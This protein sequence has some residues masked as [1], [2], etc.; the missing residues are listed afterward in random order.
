[1]TKNAAAEHAAFGTTFKRTLGIAL[2]VAWLVSNAGAQ[3]ASF[4]TDGGTPL[5]MSPGAPAGSYA[6]SG[7][8]SVNLYNGLST[9]AC[10]CCTSGA[11]VTPSL[12]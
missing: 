1:M 5:G 4:A 6:L 2:F 8:E 9:S 11:A 12:R 10:R 7:F 3:T